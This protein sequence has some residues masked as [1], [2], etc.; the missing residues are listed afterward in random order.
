MVQAPSDATGKTIAIVPTKPLEE[1]SSYMAVVTDDVKDANG[2]DATPDQTYFLTQRTSPLCTGGVSTDPLLPNATA[3]ALEPLRQLP[4]ERPG[5][6]L[7]EE[8]VTMRNGLEFHLGPTSCAAARFAH[9]TSRRM[10]TSA[11]FCR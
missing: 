7:Q 3:C 4:E 9:P 8:E 2:N 10:G 5:R 1:L 11:S 6:S